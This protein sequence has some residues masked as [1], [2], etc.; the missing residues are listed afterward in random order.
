M[1]RTSHP[2]FT[3]IT[4]ISP[5]RCLLRNPKRQPQF[6]PMCP[7]SFPHCSHFVKISPH[8]SHVSRCS[9]QVF[10]Y[11]PQVYGTKKKTK[12]RSQPRTCWAHFNPALLKATIL[13]GSE[14]TW[15]APMVVNFQSCLVLNRE[16]IVQYIPIYSHSE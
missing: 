16:A 8:V 11:F 5:C 10:P 6:T 12:G 2:V 13:V 14:P 1:D 15:A 4:L 3:L 7:I 9:P